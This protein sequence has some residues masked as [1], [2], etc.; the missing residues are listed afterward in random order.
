MGCSIEW[1]TRTRR[2]EERFPLRGAACVAEPDDEA[3]EEMSRALRRMGFATHETQSGAAACFIAANIPLELMVINV[4]LPDAK[5]L[6]LIRQFRRAH[7]GLCIIA[8]AP[9]GPGHPPTFDELARFAGADAAL[10]APASVE[11]LCELISQRLPGHAPPVHAA[12]P[13]GAFI[14]R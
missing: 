5:G 14:A 3:L 1:S 7:S 2:Q 13:K 4:L 12:P 8:L 11:T 6:Q 9:A 10:A